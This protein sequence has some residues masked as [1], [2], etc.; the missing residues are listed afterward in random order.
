ML[1]MMSDA[2]INAGKPVMSNTEVCVANSTKQISLLTDP[3][4]IVRYD[5][6]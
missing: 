2:P 5:V 3:N 1:E 4:G 6:M